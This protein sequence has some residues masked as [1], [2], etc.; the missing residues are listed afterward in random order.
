MRAASRI[1]LTHLRNLPIKTMNFRRKSKD[2]SERLFLTFLTFSRHAGK[3]ERTA[4]DQIASD[5]RFHVETMQRGEL[6]VAGRAQHQHIARHGGMG[7]LDVG[8][9]EKK[10]LRLFPAARADD[11]FSLKPISRPL[12]CASASAMSTPG[13]MGR[14]GKCPANCG[15]S[16]RNVALGD[17]EI[18]AGRVSS[19]GPRTETA[20]DAAAPAGCL[21]VQTAVY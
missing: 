9:G 18:C 19:P 16:G 11:N 10:R 5:G 1:D 12:V 3:G 4:G 14:P 8:D 17:D 7:E 15:S 2:S 20:A 13:M 21:P 6:P